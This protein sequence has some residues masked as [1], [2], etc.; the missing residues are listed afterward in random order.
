[1]ANGNPLTGRTVTWSTSNAAVAA[2]SGNGLVTGGAAGT[3]TITASSEGQNGTAAM[4]V[5]V[6]PVASVSV[7]PASATVLVGQTVQLTATAK[8]A[9]GS[10][11]PGRAVTWASSAPGVASVSASGLV[12]G[13]AAGT[14]T[15]TA[16]SEGKSGT[17]TVTVPVVP[18]ASVSVG[19]AAP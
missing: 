4:T 15:L 7:S 16:T 5:S 12:M 1:D 10:P 8:D 3:A 9:N 13:V 17:A 14:A 2:V 11:L 6:V 18:V 19:P